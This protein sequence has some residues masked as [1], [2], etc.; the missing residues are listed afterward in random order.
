[1]LK[2]HTPNTVAP[3]SASTTTEWKRQLV[4]DC[5]WFQAR[6]EFSPMEVYPTP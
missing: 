1:M 3:R 4:P 2:P 6:S 5:Y